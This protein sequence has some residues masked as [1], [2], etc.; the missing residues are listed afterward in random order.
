MS[1][2]MC[3]RPM[4]RPPPVGRGRYGALHKGR[5]RTAWRSGVPCYPR[6]LSASE[7]RRVRHLSA[8]PGAVAARAIWRALEDAAVGL[9]H[10]DP[11]AQTQ[12]DEALPHHVLHRQSHTEVS[13]ERQHGQQLGQ[14]NTLA[15]RVPVTTRSLR[16]GPLLDLCAVAQG[17]SPGFQSRYKRRVPPSGGLKRST[18]SNAPRSRDVVGIERTERLGARPA[19]MPRDGGGTA[20]VAD[21]HRAHRTLRPECP[22]TTVNPGTAASSTAS[23]RS[24]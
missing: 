8:T 22:R 9:I 19:D 6:A 11:L 3:C 14:A 1:Q 21:A 17:A 15:A 7:M 2:A 5:Y 12:G 23:Y 13:A 20:T 16:T 18:R 24:R 4:G 10:A